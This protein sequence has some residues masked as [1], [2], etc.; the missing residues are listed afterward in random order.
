MNVVRLVDLC[1]VNDCVEDVELHN[2]LI[3]GPSVVFLAENVTIAG[4]SFGC[5]PAHREALF[6]EVP[7]GS[8]VLGVIGLRRVRLIG[9]RT[10][11][12][13]FIGT[14]ETLAPI[15]ASLAEPIEDTPIPAPPFYGHL[16]R[17]EVSPIDERRR[18]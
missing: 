16:I 2:T 4:T 10:Q 9:C 5:D 12:I 17:G 7:D 3:L 14:R 13:S 11:G 18:D 1:K 15:R 8:V 6:I